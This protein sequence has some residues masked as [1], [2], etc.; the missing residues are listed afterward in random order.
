M[1][2]LKLVEA[3]NRLQGAS[4]KPVHEE[5][6]PGDDRHS[7]TAA[8]RQLGYAPTVGLEA[9]LRRTIAWMR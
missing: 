4:I 9:S 2:L 8:R 6:R 5:L 3:I 1:S 7:L